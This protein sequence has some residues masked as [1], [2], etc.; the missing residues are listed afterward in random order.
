MIFLDILTIKNLN[1]IKDDLNIKYNHKNKA[2]LISY[3][4]KQFIILTNYEQL[5]ILKK[6]NIKYKNPIVIKTNYNN[7]K[8]SDLKYTLFMKNMNYNKKKSDLIKSLNILDYYYNIPLSKIIH[9]Q[10]MLKYVNIKNNIKIQG[11]SLYN[12][13]LC[14][15]NEEFMT[16]DNI[17]EIEN[18]YFIS[19]KDNDKF[20]YGFDIRSIN[21]MIENK[22]D[23]INPYTRNLFPNRFINN[24]KY[25]I[26]KLKKKNIVL[27][28]DDDKDEITDNNVILKNKIMEIC[29]KIDDLGYYSILEW[30]T[31]LSIYQYKKFNEYL[32][33]IWQ[34]R[35]Q[36][37]Q[38]LKNKIVPPNGQPFT[39]TV[40]IINSYNCIESVRNYVFSTIN[41]ILNSAENI[42]DQKLGCMY[43]LMALTMVNNMAAQDLPWLYQSAMLI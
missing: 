29:T 37:P 2:D 15:N 42:E 5:D 8:I 24:I 33:D 18:K 16:Y 4:N 26:D 25:Y 1:K 35:L 36:L 12:R 10:N 17:D 28:L 9:L 22:L 32:V 38:S 21:Y 40:N 6:L 19:Y 13:K 23:L 30:F 11:I 34:Y 39:K 43:I 41:K 14:N 7:S 31:T 20:Y 3:I 27:Y